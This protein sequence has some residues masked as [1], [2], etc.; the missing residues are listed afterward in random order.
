MNRAVFLLRKNSIDVYTI[1]VIKIQSDVIN[2][3]RC[4]FKLRD[5]HYRVCFSTKEFSSVCVNSK[6][7]S[8]KTRVVY[9]IQIRNGW[10]HRS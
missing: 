6:E 9:T 1:I 10:I 7:N 3:T 4:K 8:F 5:L 2:N